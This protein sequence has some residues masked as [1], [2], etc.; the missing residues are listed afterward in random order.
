M[1]KL[2]RFYNM[3]KNKIWLSVIWCVFLVILFVAFK[4]FMIEKD[5]K[6]NEIRDSYIANSNQNNKTKYEDKVTIKSDTSISNPY[7]ETDIETNI[8]K[9]TITQFAEEINK[10]NIEASYNMIT[11]ECK[12]ILY[13][14]LE[15]FYNNYVIENWKKGSTYEL[16]KWINNTY[17]VNII[18]DLL[19]SGTTKDDK[20][21][22]DY[23]T[24]ES[25]N[26]EYK[27]NVNSYIGRK[28]INKTKTQGNLTINVNYKD[29]FMNNEIY[30]FTFQNR[31]NS[32]II[33]DDLK[34]ANSMYI[35]TKKGKKDYAYT[36]EL[37]KENLKLG[38][39]EK[40]NINIKYY[41][42]HTLDKEISTIVFTKVKENPIKS[43]EKSKLIEIDIG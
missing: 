35:M 11:K 32:S 18:P 20:I 40:K 22:M 2:I 33:I 21:K 1:N 19:S 16:E 6:K 17:K 10:G 42:R 12:E 34:D 36:N 15:D 24:V 43:E 13:P 14:T 30:N 26:N 8:I 31:G 5:K 25:I 3:N 41:S 9:R 28:K 37:T 38:I 29:I 39:G 4:N 7:D 27:V 23:V